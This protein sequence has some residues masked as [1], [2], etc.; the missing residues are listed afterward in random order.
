MR[1]SIEPVVS[2]VTGPAS[3][4][5]WAI[6]SLSGIA[7]PLVQVV[8]DG[9]HRLIHA[10]HIRL[11]AALLDRLAKLPECVQEFAVRKEAL[12]A[13]PVERH[14]DVALELRQVGS[15]EGRLHRPPTVE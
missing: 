12:E 3:G 1:C 2:R 8:P 6:R 11:V 7:L 5:T 9:G 14:G 13:L 15:E 10:A 4:A